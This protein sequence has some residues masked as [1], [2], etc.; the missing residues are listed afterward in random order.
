MNWIPAAQITPLGCCGAFFSERLWLV[1]RI[2]ANRHQNLHGQLTHTQVLASC[3]ETPYPVS[4]ARGL[5]FRPEGQAQYERK[6]QDFPC[7]NGRFGGLLR[8][9][10]YLIQ[11]ITELA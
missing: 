5:E 10:L 6:S 1:L 7:H 8:Y 3:I 9:I 4:K 2:R 11:Y